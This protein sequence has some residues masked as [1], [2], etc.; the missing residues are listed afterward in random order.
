MNIKLN[1]KNTTIMKCNTFNSNKFISMI[2]YMYL[3]ITYLSYLSTL[4]W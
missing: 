3:D 1:I 2:M 4:P